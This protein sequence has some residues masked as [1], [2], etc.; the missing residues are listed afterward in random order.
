MQLCNYQSN[1]CVKPIL[2]VIIDWIM[3]FV[4]FKVQYQEI[5]LATEQRH[6]PW[7]SRSALILT[8]EFSSSELPV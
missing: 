3:K 5:L 6:W 1:F 2:R 8:S 7:N 4:P